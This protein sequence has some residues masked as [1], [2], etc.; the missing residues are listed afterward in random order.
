MSS[1]EEFLAILRQYAPDE[2]DAVEGTDSHSLA[3]EAKEEKGDAKNT[4]DSSSP[5]SSHVKSPSANCF[6]GTNSTTEGWA[7]SS[8]SFV[9]QDNIPRFPFPA[10]HFTLEEPNAKLNS[11]RK[12][13]GWNLLHS[14]HRKKDTTTCAT[15]NKEFLEKRVPCGSGPHETC[16]PHHH[17]ASAMTARYEV[18][19]GNRER[20][21]RMHTR[22][23]VEREG[24]GAGKKRGREEAQAT[25]S[26]SPS[27]SPFS[28][29]ETY[30]PLS[31]GGFLD[32][33]DGSPDR[34]RCMILG[35]VVVVL[36]TPSLPSSSSS[37]SLST[38]SSSK[39]S[40][41]SSRFVP[42]VAKEAH[43]FPLSNEVSPM[44]VAS[45][46][47]SS[48]PDSCLSSSPIS[49][50][51]AP[52]NIL[53]KI[54]QFVPESALTS[55]EKKYGRLLDLK[56]WHSIGEVTRCDIYCREVE[57]LFLSGQRKKFP[58]VALRPAGF[59][60]QE[61]FMQWK[62]E[63][64]SRPVGQIGLPRRERYGEAERVVG[65][66]PNTLSSEGSEAQRDHAAPS[67][68]FSPKKGI[69]SSVI[70]DSSTTSIPALP[71]TCSP[72][73]SC[74]PPTSRWWVLPHLIVRVVADDAG[75]TWFGQKAV[76]LHIQRKEERMRL[77]R[78]D[79]T[80]PISSL[81]PFSHSLPLERRGGGAGVAGMPATPL[82]SS[83]SSSLSSS[84]SF[85]YP[86]EDMVDV[87]G[88]RSVETVV[89]RVGEAGMLVLGKRKGEL[90]EVVRR[91]RDEKTGDLK[92]LLVLPRSSVRATAKSLEAKGKTTTVRAG[93][94]V[95][96]GNSGGSD[97]S[98]KAGAL[99][100]ESALLE[101]AFQ[102]LPEEICAFQQ[103]K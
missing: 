95:V 47:T 65:R 1:R 67:L 71:S 61:L 83:S 63:P 24:N 49:T 19:S 11:S 84:L 12:K 56:L 103:P 52:F 23:V 59:M 69:A 28:T 76:V 48:A 62:T 73:S 29:V 53:Q 101:E 88:V 89:P 10:S 6:F 92:F 4:T 102:V 100:E 50:S 34:S 85:G 35:A 94:G 7:S 54:K 21:S 51:P 68:F 75:P 39:A 5:F 40:S 55:E 60:E 43:M 98:S 79:S 17:G 20:G 16:D 80:R 32:S 93:N 3:I 72:I 97:R 70:T 14:M 13:V 42:G 44:V 58:V 31:S 74:T 66:T 22:E 82:P 27:S 91:C 41:E 81:Q 64:S 33:V 26:P 57:V 77:V 15:H 9:V 87:F 25:P 2:D 8:S 45:S 18:V 46:T 99:T 36:S 78:W 38:T 96:D 90:V 30:K 37:S 86:A